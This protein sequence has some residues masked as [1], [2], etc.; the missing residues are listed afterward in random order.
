MMKINK[1]S[2]IW[3]SHT[4]KKPHCAL[5]NLKPYMQNSETTH[6]C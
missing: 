4:G 3:Q 2:E 6:L 5:T 1:K